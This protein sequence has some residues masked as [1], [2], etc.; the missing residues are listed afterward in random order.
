MK[1]IVSDLLLHFALLIGV[2][3]YIVMLSKRSKE[4]ITIR[5]YEQHFFS[6]HYRNY[7]VEVVVLIIYYEFAIKR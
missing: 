4:K 2:F 6:F 7:V 5:I 3:R 1:V